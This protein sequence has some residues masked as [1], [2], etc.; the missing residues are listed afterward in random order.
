MLMRIWSCENEFIIK[1]N[2]SLAEIIIKNKTE[3]LLL[4]VSI[5][6][7]FMNMKNRKSDEAHYLIL[8]L[9]QRLDLRSSDKHVALQK[10]SIYYTWKNTRKQYKKINQK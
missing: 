10:L 8:N 7:I 2:E 4:K 1:T 9:S 6:T 3:Q 5:E